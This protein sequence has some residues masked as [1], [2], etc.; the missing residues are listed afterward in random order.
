MKD[1][2]L[3]RARTD[4]M[5]E[6]EAFDFAEAWERQMTLLVRTSMALSDAKVISANASWERSAVY[7]TNYWPGEGQLWTR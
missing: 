5:T 4:G 6:A 2:L 3:K 7:L 1:R